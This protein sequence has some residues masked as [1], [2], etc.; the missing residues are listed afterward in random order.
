MAS[1]STRRNLV[2]EGTIV[3]TF[4]EHQHMCLA[5]R[6]EGDGADGVAVEYI[7]R[8]PIAALAGLTNAERKALLVAAV[9]A[10]RDAQVTPDQSAP[11]VSG[12]VTL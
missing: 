4:I 8:V 7:G 10:V 5:V 1:T 2:A 12:T 6:V 3:G 11:A 9:K